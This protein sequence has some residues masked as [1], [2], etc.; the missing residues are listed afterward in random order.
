LILLDVNNMH[1]FLW[2]SPFFF[3]LIFLPISFCVMEDKSSNVVVD[4]DWGF[5]I[6]ELLGGLS[7][8]LYGMKLMTDSLKASTGDKMKDILRS[9]SS[10][11]MVA[12]LTGIFV[13]G[14]LQSSAVVSV[15]VVG[16]VSSGLM[17][18]KQTLGILLGAG[19]GTTLTSQMVAFDVTKYSLWLVTIGFAM[20]TFS[21]RQ[22][23]EYYGIGTLGLGLVF[24]GIDVMSASMVPLRSYQP[25]LNILVEMSNPLLA[26][27]VSSIFTA[28]IQS[29]TATVGIVMA[30]SSQKLVTLKAGVSL[31]L[32][33][34]VGTGITAILAGL[35]S[36]REAKRVALA[37]IL[38]KVA[39]VVVVLPFLSQFM[40]FLQ[41]TSSE[42]P[43]QLANAHTF[44]NIGVAILFLPFSDQI[45]E[46]VL[47]LL[48]DTSDQHA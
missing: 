16:F 5:L 22:M 10:S 45:A 12:L 18:F 25:F 31:I 44:W 9:L 39:G 41:S 40:A 42:M 30:L 28:L 20:R 38:F 34:N 2:I 1:S 36:T 6:G 27:I 29:S 21:S 33:A 37:N 32:G 11:K 8:F 47:R 4:L 43:R 13:T 24:Y 26:I 7:L 17:S 48:P 23:M 14:V 19:I 3:L 35:S 15:M 46:L